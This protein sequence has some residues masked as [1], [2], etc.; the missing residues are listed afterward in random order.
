MA[1]LVAGAFRRVT[2]SFGFGL[3]LSSHVV[4]LHSNAHVCGTTRE[5][6]T[7]FSLL[8]KVVS[9]GHALSIYLGIRSRKRRKTATAGPIVLLAINSKVSV[10]G[11]LALVTTGFDRAD[12]LF[13]DVAVA[14]RKKLRGNPRMFQ[15][16]ART[17]QC[18]V[19]DK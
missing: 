9:T 4:E 18:G 7:D 2:L 16:A 1:C 13:Q 6:Q 17:K 19:D 14:M 12:D 3:K 8:Q 10:I 11:A 15:D 5:S